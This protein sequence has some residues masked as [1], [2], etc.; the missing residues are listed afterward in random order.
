MMRLVRPLIPEEDDSGKISSPGFQGAIRRQGKKVSREGE[1]VEARN[2]G[3]SGRAGTTDVSLPVAETVDGV[4]V[5]SDATRDA[6]PW[7]SN[8]LSVGCCGGRLGVATPA[9]WGEDSKRTALLGSARAVI[10]NARV[11][12]V[13]DTSVAGARTRANMCVVRQTRLAGRWPD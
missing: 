1:D 5:V 4:A 7:F 8:A 11:R 9:S 10:G 13:W 6:A 12:G 2:M 3:M